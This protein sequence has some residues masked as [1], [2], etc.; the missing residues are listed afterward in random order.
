MFA[1]GVEFARPKT[2]FHHKKNGLIFML[3]EKLVMYLSD[4]NFFKLLSMFPVLEQE[5]N[6]V[7]T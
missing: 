5:K 4:Y 6:Y 1:R 2:P 7:K 3:L